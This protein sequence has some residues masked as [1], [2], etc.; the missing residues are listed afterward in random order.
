MN[1]S[2]AVPLPLSMSASE[3]AAWYRAMVPL[4]PDLPVG[5]YSGDNE[6]ELAYS[7]F[8]A[9]WATKSMLRLAAAHSLIEQ[10]IAEEFLTKFKLCS[11]AEHVGRAY[12]LGEGKYVFSYA[13]DILKDVP[14]HEKRLFP[15]TIGESIG[16]EYQAADGIYVVTEDGWMKKNG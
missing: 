9:Y 7:K 6:H 3:A 10:A 5:A 11:A 14:E 8:S 12:V 1:D 13:M 15:G 4:I 2:I 16:L